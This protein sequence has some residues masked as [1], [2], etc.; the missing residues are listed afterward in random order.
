MFTPGNGYSVSLL[1]NKERSMCF[2]GTSVCAGWLALSSVH[3]E[4]L[5]CMYVC[6][7]RYL[8]SRRETIIII[9]MHGTLQLSYHCVQ[10]QFRY[11]CN[12]RMSMYVHMFVSS[13]VLFRS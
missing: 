10:F 8:L 5:M 11:T 9:I 2:E 3:S 7:R 1:V 4:P 12:V 13:R 6:M